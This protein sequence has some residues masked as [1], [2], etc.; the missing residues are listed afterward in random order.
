MKYEIRIDYSTGDSFGNE[1]RDNEDLGLV[2]DTVE[3][4]EKALMEIKEH[5]E[6]VKEFDHAW[7][8]RMHPRVTAGRRFKSEIIQEICEKPWFSDYDRDYWQFSIKLETSEGQRT[9]IHV[10]YVGYFEAL[11]SARAVPIG[12]NTLEIHF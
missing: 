12:K 5:Y 1:D 3:L 11:R 4:A 10:F 2:F 6:Y 7:N 8:D 9:Q